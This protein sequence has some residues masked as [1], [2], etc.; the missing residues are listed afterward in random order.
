[1]CVKVVE[2]ANIG[3]VQK[4]MM[5]RESK[6]LRQ[7]N[8]P[9]ILRLI[10]VLDKGSQFYLVTEYCPQGDLNKK[11]TT[12]GPIQEYIAFHLMKGVANALLALKKSGIVHRDL[13]PSNVLLKDGIAKLADFGFAIY[14]SQARE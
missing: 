9:N 13:K 12:E 7:L 6:I 1:M 3:Q 4:N 8:H 2:L 11:L 5:F 10:D 14:E